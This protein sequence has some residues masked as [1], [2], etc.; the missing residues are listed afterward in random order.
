MGKPL[1]RSGRGVC[2]CPRSRI[3]LPVEAALIFDVHAQGA[4]AGIAS[5]IAAQI[6]VAASAQSRRSMPD[7]RARAAG[8]LHAPCH[9]YTSGPLRMRHVFFAEREAARKSP[10]IDGVKLAQN[11][12]DC[13]R[14]RH[15]GTMGS[16]IARFRPGRTRAIPVVI[17]VEQNE[18]ASVA[19]ARAQ[20]PRPMP[21]LERNPV[22]SRQLSAD[23]LSAAACV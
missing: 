15:A 12:R 9:G 20:S 11:V 16:G 8:S 23:G 14:G 17:N 21:R 4:R 7:S 1:R 10:V 19:R 5:A 6:V 13:R 2:P 3:L 22:A 18:E